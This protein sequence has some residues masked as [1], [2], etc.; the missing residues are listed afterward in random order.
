MIKRSFSGLSQ[1]RLKYDLVETDPGGPEIVPDPSDFILLVDD[2][3]N[4]ARTA[5]LQK[6]DRVRKGEKLSLYKDST[7]YVISPVS[8]VIQSIESL[9]GEFG[10]VKTYLVIKK[11]ESDESVNDFEQHADK[12]E[13]ETAAQFLKSLPGAPPFKALTDPEKKI[14]TIVISGVDEDLA[15][16]TRQYF[17]SAESEDLKE[18]IKILQKLTKAPKIILTIPQGFSVETQIPGLQVF[19][20]PPFYPNALSEM[21]MKNQLKI[22]IPQGKTCEDLGVCFISS[23]AVVSLARAYRDKK[24]S[25]GKLVCVTSKDGVRK[26]MLVSIGT[27][28]KSIFKQLNIHI[29]DNDRIIMGGPFKGFSVYNIY[30]PVE[31]CTDSIIIQDSGDVPYV[32]NSACINC[33]KCIRICPVNIPVNLLVRQLEVS[34]FEDAKEM[35]DL[36]SCIECGLCS[37]VCTAKIP[38]FQY[39]RLGKHELLKIEAE[40]ATEDVNE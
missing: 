10:D 17:L 22:T 36:E 6:D 33:G 12:Y 11:D 39:I 15:A 19:N 9:P 37:Y 3:L 26:R 35:F 24:I 1:P 27:P 18:G 31:P 13:L 30:H 23:E 28:V 16:S 38:V 29:N 21:I 4:S 5:L 14:H 2:S 20:I 25:Y 40:A 34:R 7:E 8:G 32:S